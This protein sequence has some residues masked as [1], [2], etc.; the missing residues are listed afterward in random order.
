MTPPSLWPD[1]VRRAL[2]TLAILLVAAIGF[3]AG[4]LVFDDSGDEAPSSSSIV[5]VDPGTADEDDVAAEP[6]ASSTFPALATRN[7]TRVAGADPTANAAGVALASYPSAGDVPGPS[8]VV[9]ASSDSWQQALAATPLTADPID[10]PILLATA[11]EVPTLTTDALAALAPTGLA[12][13]KGAE[14][15]AVGEVVEPEDAETLTIDEA[16]P[17]KLAD[18]IDEERARLTGVDHPAHLLVVSSKLAQLAMPAAAWAARSGDPILFADGDDVPEA[19]LEVI[20]RHPRTPIYVLGPGS[21]ISSKALKELAK[22]GALVNRVGNEDPVENAIDFARYVDGDFGWNINDPGHGFVIANADRPLD[23]AAAAPLSAGGKPGPLLLTDDATAV[24]RA[25]QGFLS[26]TQ[27]G[28]IEDPSRALYNHV[29][30][31]GDPT[32]LSVAFQVQVDALTKLAR[33]SDGTA[34]EGF[35]SG[36]AESEP[37]SD[38]GAKDDRKNDAAG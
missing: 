19:T 24:P 35:G 30:L 31:L 18:R 36:G 1:A 22:K 28:F 16:D 20:K 29:W 8:A 25:L 33:V 23:A 17:A 32:A 38:G 11:D 37:R 27:P 34:P 15:I 7:T 13:E 2:A 21:A 26:D 10:A 6:A 9:L 5:V 4:Y 14:V 3:G 12:K